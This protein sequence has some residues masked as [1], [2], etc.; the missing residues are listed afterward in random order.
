MTNPFLSPS[1][2]DPFAS[3]EADKA[4]AMIED[5]VAGASRVAPCIK[6]GVFQADADNLA[7][8]RA[9]LRAVVLRRNEAGAGALEQQAAGPFSV[10]LDT[11]QPH[12]SL[13]WPS[14]IDELQAICREYNGQGKA[15]AFAVDTAPT[16]GGWHV[17]WCSIAFG[18]TYCSCGA[19]I[20]GYPIYE[21]G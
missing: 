17:P 9:V 7:A 21:Q 4:N 1:D 8:V 11:R 20:A 13:F 2:L 15:G 18:A 3:I 5:A 14:E 19:D 16:F 6:E 10:G 12:R